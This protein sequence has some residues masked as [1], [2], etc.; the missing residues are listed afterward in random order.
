MAIIMVLRRHARTR[1]EWDLMDERSKNPYKELQKKDYERY[2][3]AIQVWNAKK[4]RTDGEQNAM[5]PLY[6]VRIHA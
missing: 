2:K 5:L 1:A 6:H 4:S 3:K